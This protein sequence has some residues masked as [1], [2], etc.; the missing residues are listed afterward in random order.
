MRV[1]IG[2]LWTESSSLSPLLANREMF[3][4][5][6]LVEGEALL[7]FYEGT[8]TEVGGFLAAL[9]EAEVEPVPL[10]GAQAACAGP[11]ERAFWEWSRDRMIALLCDAGPVD[12][13]LLSLHGATLAEDEDDVCGALLAAVRDLVGRAVPIAATLDLHANPTALMARSAD[14]LI[15]YKTYP[16]HDFVDRGRQA[17][18]IALAA[19]RG[20][21]SPV[22]TVTTI[23]MSLGSLPLLEE[24]IARAVEFEEQPGVLC[25]SIVP[26]HPHLDVA[27]FRPLS[28]VVVSDGDPALG[29]RIGRDLMRAAWT[30]RERAVAG[31]PR[32]RTLPEAID[33]ALDFPHGTVVIAD[34]FDAVTAGFPGDSPEVIRALLDRGVREPACLILTD[35]GF[36][37]Q[38]EVTGIGGTMAGPLGGVWG[39][40]GSGP[41]EVVARVRA[42]TDGTLMKSREPRPGHLEISNTRMGRTAVV[43]IGATI[44]VVVTSVPVM[45]TEPTVFRSTGVEPYDHRIVV[46]K[47][48]NQ[49]RF[50]YGEAVGFVDLGGPGW[51]AAEKTYIWRRRPSR[52]LFPN[53]DVTDDEIE[54]ALAQES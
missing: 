20:E 14:A 39:G 11:I 45:S 2:R 47:S 6:A 31:T 9:T 21:T 7:R 18:G 33:E 46:T 43:V 28:A 37:R 32:L 3:E 50:H 53:D 25:C 52:R 17:T 29:R 41:L 35:P 16:H 8:R 36:V 30:N 42:L 5:G 15:A 49:Q 27:E 34:R 4:A 19:A 13:V 51:G 22:T 26:T 1:A 38:A 48:V 23:P 24:L 54:A 40:P 12:A 10:L 44:T